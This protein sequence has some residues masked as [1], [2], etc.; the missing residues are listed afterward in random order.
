M[1][2]TFVDEI[3]KWLEEIYPE[4]PWWEVAPNSWI[5]GAAIGG[6]ISIL[7]ERVITRLYKALKR[8]WRSYKLL[9][10]I[11]I[12]ESSHSA[13]ERKMDSVDF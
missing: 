11:N 12:L 6:L 5:L 2:S 13:S 10:P 9:K 3:L 4:Q 1:N 7:L 8:R